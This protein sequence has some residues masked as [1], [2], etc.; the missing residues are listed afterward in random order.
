MIQPEIVMNWNMVVHLPE[1]VQMQF[2]AVIAGY[3][4]AVYQHIA[5]QE[6]SR[7]PRARLGSQ[8]GTQ[9]VPLGVGAHQSAAE[10]VKELMSS[11][12][13]QKLFL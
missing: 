8:L 6:P 2:S 12:M 11:E 10:F 5:A 3:M 13:A 9:T 4:S 1:S 7:T